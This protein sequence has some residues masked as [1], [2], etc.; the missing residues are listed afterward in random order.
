MPAILS[1]G[2]EGGGGGLTPAANKTKQ[3][4]VHILWDIVLSY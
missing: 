1:R 4:K 2:V 3:G